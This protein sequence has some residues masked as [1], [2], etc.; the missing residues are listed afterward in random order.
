MADNKIVRISSVM[1]KEI[2]PAID[3]LLKKHAGGRVLWT[4]QVWS[5]D[6]RGDM[7]YI[8]NV[9][10]NDVKKAMAE[11][12]QKWDRESHTPAHERN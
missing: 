4:L 11:C 6:E 7:A 2:A 9:D 10:R 8:G 12:V 3:A 5:G 1:Q